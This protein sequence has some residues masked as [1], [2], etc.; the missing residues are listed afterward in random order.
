M[1]TKTHTSHHQPTV[2]VAVEFE[3][4]QIH[5]EVL[6]CSPGEGDT[7]GTWLDGFIQHSMQ[8]GDHLGRMTIDLAEFSKAFIPQRRKD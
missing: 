2:P 8:E 4:I 6:A 7:V 1:K 5:H 3:V